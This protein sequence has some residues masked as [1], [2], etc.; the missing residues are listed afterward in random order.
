MNRK[1][2]R[3]V[4]AGLCATLVCAVLALSCNTAMA[5]WAWKDD[6]GHTVFSD[7]PP[8]AGMPKTR[9]LKSPGGSFSPTPAAAGDAPAAASSADGDSKPKSLAEQNLEFNKRLKDNQ[10]AAKKAA[11]A[12]AQADQKK[13][14]CADSR[15]ALANLTS[16]QRIATTDAQGNR[17]YLDDSQRQ[18]EAAR[19]QSGMTGC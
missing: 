13:Q 17:V 18:A 6:Q 15:T 12:Q 5:Q 11:E 9:I 19:V 1:V 4:A 10:D 8:P 7:Q 2:N 14:H 3:K 16:G